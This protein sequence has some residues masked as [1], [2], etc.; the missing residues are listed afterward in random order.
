MI[1]WLKSLWGAW[2]TWK[3]G[4]PW[5]DTK[6]SPDWPAVRRLHLSRE[7]L[8][9]WCGGGEH[10]QVH[11]IFPFH[12][13]PYLELYDGVNGTGRDGNL[14]SLCERPDTQCHF[15]QGHKG[16][17]SSYDPGIAG[18]CMARQIE[19]ARQRQMIGLLP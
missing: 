7:P 10:V 19:A 15:R 5:D 1:G 11:H 3:T 9:Q 12:L 4:K 6:R 14:I 8:C 17:W 16:D 13:F 2:R 18:K